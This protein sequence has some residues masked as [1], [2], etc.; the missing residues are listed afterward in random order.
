[1]GWIAVGFRIRAFAAPPGAGELPLPRVACIVASSLVAAVILLLPRPSAHTG[2]F[3][4][5]G[6][7]PACD[8]P[9]ELAKVRARF[10]ATSAQR[11]QGAVLAGIA[12]PVVVIRS[13]MVNTCSAQLLFTDGR[14]KELLYRVLAA[15]LPTES[16]LPTAPPRVSSN[17]V[18][19]PPKP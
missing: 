12:S 9:A 17:A 1:M 14:T 10:E 7:M 5:Y 15:P 2:V 19:P 6:P 4:L 3:L 13:P 8:A 16:D 11:P 18:P